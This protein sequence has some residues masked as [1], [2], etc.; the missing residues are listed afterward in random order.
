MPTAMKKDRVVPAI[1]IEDKILSGDETIRL[2]T[3]EKKANYL[4]NILEVTIAANKV[5][6]VT[7]DV[8][9]LKEIKVEKLMDLIESGGI[10]SESDR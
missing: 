5:I 1:R 10:L 4:W 9:S 8:P 6:H 7:R 2:Y 3:L